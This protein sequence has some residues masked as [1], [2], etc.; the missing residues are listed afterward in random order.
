MMQ[1]PG[2]PKKALF[3]LVLSTAVALA[4][5]G[6][7]F[8][9]DPAHDLPVSLPGKDGR[10]ESM[11]ET[12]AVADLKGKLETFDG[13]PATLPGE[14]PRFR[15][16]DC[17]N[18]VK[19]APALASTWPK[20]GPKV[21]WQ[22]ELGEGHAAAVVGQGRVFVLD[23]DEQK[24][25]DAARCFSLADGK[26][27]W[28]RSYAVSTKRNHGMSRTVPALTG[29]YL[30]TLGPRCHVVCL[31]PAT[32]DFKWGIDLQAEY[33][34]AEPLWY[35]GQCPMIDGDKLI[36][37]PG[38]KDALLMAVDLATGKPVWKTPN[39]KLWNMSHASIMPM[40]LAGKRMYVYSALG[41]IVGVS[42][43]A[44]DAGTLLWELPWNARV[45]APSP[46]PLDEGKIYATA[47]YGYGSLMMQVHADGG[48]FTAESLFQKSPSDF[49]ASEQQ[50]PIYTGGLLYGIM[51]KD[52]GALRGQFVCY[53]PDGTLAWSS[54]PENRFGL[55]P[56][57]LADGKFFILG[58]DGLLTMI[59][60]DAGKY[61]QLGQARIFDGQDAWGPLALAGTRLLLRDS[62]RMACVEIGAAAQ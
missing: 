1:S 36:L 8:I 17:D 7:W 37:A 19:D 45:A 61:E 18:I 24:K 53:K 10:P 25:A 40:T 51:P 28:R 49:L 35:A 58:D 22:V 52:G 27:I 47:G 38:G 26:E 20:D 43:D 34:T 14:W 55:G 2:P 54:G 31:S 60:A 12:G 39:P 21:L 30:I 59:K 62:K 23:Y 11:P 50:T 16:K 13:T 48:K 15:G 6:G 9:Y 57:L 33:G 46:V 44:A 29:E 32:G 56:F 4:V 41:G 3:V 5:L 42:A